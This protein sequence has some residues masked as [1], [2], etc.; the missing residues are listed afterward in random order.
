M[1][2]AQSIIQYLM[3]TYRKHEKSDENTYTNQA[4]DDRK[5]ASYACKMST[6]LSQLKAKVATRAIRNC[7]QLL[8]STRRQAY[9]ITIGFLHLMEMNRNGTSCKNKNIYLVPREEHDPISPSHTLTY[10][11]IRLAAHPILT[12]AYN[13]TG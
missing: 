12:T 7:S 6:A 11:S 4:T 9:P 8:T 2:A 5:L 1:A 13:L 3:K 10:P